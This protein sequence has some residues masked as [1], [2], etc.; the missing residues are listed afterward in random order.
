[1]RIGRRRSGPSLSVL[2]LS[3]A[4]D[5]PQKAPRK[6][7]LGQGKRY[8]YPVPSRAWSSRDVELTWQSSGAGPAADLW[9][10]SRRIFALRSVTVMRSRLASTCPCYGRRRCTA[11]QAS[12]I[13]SS[14]QPRDRRTPHIAVASRRE[15]GRTRSRARLA[16]GRVKLRETRR[17]RGGRCCDRAVC[18]G[19]DGWPSQARR[20]RGRGR[21]RPERTRA[22]GH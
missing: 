4:S 20:D 21:G 11:C 5:A 1:M 3:G 10:P 2:P 8:W 12:A 17:R 19:A 16:A 13:V 18:R 7:Q 14:A 22:R 6:S 9:L 15:V